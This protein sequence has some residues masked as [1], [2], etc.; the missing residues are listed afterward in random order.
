MDREH[1]LVQELMP[2]GTLKDYL[3]DRAAIRIAYGLGR[4]AVQFKHPDAHFDWPLR[5]RFLE[6]ICSAMG[7][8]HSRASP[9]I[10]RDLKPANCLLDSNYRVKVADFGTVKWKL[11]LRRQSTRKGR[12]RTGC[13][14]SR[15]STKQPDAAG[16]FEDD[17]VAEETEPVGT[18]L[19]MAPECFKKTMKPG[20]KVDVW[21]FSFVVFEICC[22]EKPFEGVRFFMSKIESGKRPTD[23]MTG[24]LDAVPQVLQDLMVQCWQKEPALRPLFRNGPGETGATVADQLLAAAS[25]LRGTTSV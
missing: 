13:S 24:T 18:P 15:L 9:M 2:N 4:N 23:F 6:D 22:R 12:K 19:Y 25:T 1:F 7:F 16:D 5:C 20:L 11:R 8:L 10:H 21:S 3:H 17:D 14:K